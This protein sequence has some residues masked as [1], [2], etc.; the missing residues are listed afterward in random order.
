[1]PLV[2]DMFGPALAYLLTEPPARTDWYEIGARRS[3][4]AEDEIPPS[5]LPR[6]GHK[7]AILGVTR[8]NFH[9]PNASWGGHADVPVRLAAAVIDGGRRGSADTICYWYA[10]KHEPLCRPTGGG[11]LWWVAFRS[12]FIGFSVLGR[13]SR[14]AIAQGCGPKDASRFPVE[15]DEVATAAEELYEIYQDRFMKATVNLIM[16]LGQDTT[17]RTQLLTPTNDSTQSTS[18]NVAKKADGSSTSTENRVSLFDLPTEL[19]TRIWTEALQ[20][21]SRIDLACTCWTLYME[22]STILYQRPVHFASQKKLFT[23]IDRSESAD[24]ARVRFL[25]LRLTDVDLSPLF[26][27]SPDS[28][29]HRITAWD[30]YQRELV[31]LD[32]AL[33]A[34]PSLSQLILVPPDRNKSMF[35][36]SMYM[37]FLRRIP[38]RCLKLERLI[39]HDDNNVLQKVPELRRLAKVVCESSVSSHGSSSLLGAISD[40][41]HSQV[42]R[43]ERAVIKE[44]FASDES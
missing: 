10:P 25:T 30:L 24:L 14:K 19:R 3:L 8:S 23:W 11:G 2:P 33:E 4:A 9:R 15:Y 29:G 22:T 36:K 34:L 38:I 28:Q 20:D 13:T 21:S 44:E 1:M 12:L 40:S 37:C 6:S 7:E 35:L 16:P 27:A 43:E 26:V 5:N 18:I 41:P 31:H 42:K 32:G 39:V 17:L